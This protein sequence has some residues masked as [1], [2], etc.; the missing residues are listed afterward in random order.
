M[1]VCL[2]LLLP[3][4][5]ILLFILP[6]FSLLHPTISQS[7]PLQTRSSAVSHSA[8]INLDSKSPVPAST[9]KIFLSP[10]Q[11]SK[12]LTHLNPC[13]L[14]KD[15]DSPGWIAWHSS[16][17]MNDL[18]FQKSPDKSQIS[19]FLLCNYI[20]LFIPVARLE[21]DRLLKHAQSLQLAGDK[22]HTILP[23]RFSLWPC[24]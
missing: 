13:L 14:K 21:S 22:S 8:R 20:G 10:T 19:Y 12:K 7:Q 5:Q 24:Y 15:I 1:I 16:R 6:L 2:L 18:S 3:L 4:C 17:Q 9:R 23:G 11:S